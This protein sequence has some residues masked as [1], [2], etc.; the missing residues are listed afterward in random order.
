MSLPELPVLDDCWNRN[1]VW[2][3]ERPRCPKL[4]EHIHCYNCE[5][6]R[7]AGNLLRDRP[8]PAD[9]QAEWTEIVANRKPARELDGLA[10]LVFRLGRE[11]LALPA[12]LVD[13]IVE[14]R[15]I[16]SL[17]HRPSPVLLGLVNIRGKL[18]LCVSPAAV[19]GIAAAGGEPARQKRDGRG[20]YPRMLL[21]RKELDIFVFPVDEILGTHRY[22]PQDLEDLPA[23]LTA[24]LTRFST[25][26]L[27]VEGRNVGLLDPDLLFHAFGRSLA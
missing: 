21:V 14:M 1:G 2:G 6:F 22:A 12:A 24:A 19:L 5:V 10:V 23:T 8:L 17:P 7:A 16:H 20:V 15:S 25:G 11:W 3:R 4:E 13:E 27:D 18:R 26:V 9:Y